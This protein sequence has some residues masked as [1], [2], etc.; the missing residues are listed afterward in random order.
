MLG[1]QLRSKSLATDLDLRREVTVSF[2]LTSSYLGYM[3]GAV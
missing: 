3:P 1:L 2:D